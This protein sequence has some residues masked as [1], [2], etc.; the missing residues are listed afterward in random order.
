MSVRVVVAGLLVG[1][2]GILTMGAA[3]FGERLTFN[4][5]D[6]FMQ[7]HPEAF[8]LPAN[9]AKLWMGIVTLWMGLLFGFLCDLAR[10]AG[11][12]GAARLGL[13]CWLGFV[14]PGQVLMLLWTQASLH[15]LGSNAVGYLLQL[16]LGGL[17]LPRVLGYRQAEAPAR[18]PAPS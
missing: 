16:I 4:Q 13:V 3:H 15:A 8:P 17:V 10:P 11:A 18:P 14:V 6:K 5:I 9:Q 7:D 2:L 1:V 12:W